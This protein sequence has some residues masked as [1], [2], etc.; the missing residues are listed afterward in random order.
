MCIVHLYTYVTIVYFDLNAKRLR[1]IIHFSTCKTKSRQKRPRYNHCVR[2][3][4]IYMCVY[5][6]VYVCVLLCIDMY[7]YV[8]ICMRANAVDSPLCSQLFPIHFPYSKSSSG[9]VLPPP[10]KIDSPKYLKNI[11][12][13][14]TWAKKAKNSA[15]IRWP[16]NSLPNLFPRGAVLARAICHALM[17]NLGDAS[18]FNSSNI[19]Y[20][21]YSVVC[22]TQIRKQWPH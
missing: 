2:M 15:R 14:Q 13:S 19:C 21:A 16:S 18:G 11:W 3:Y 7:W 4:Y 20:C 17:M 10:L 1:Y 12:H 9:A 8:L 5:M 22:L 6:Y